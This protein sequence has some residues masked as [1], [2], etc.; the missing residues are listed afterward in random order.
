MMQAKPEVIEEVRRI[1]LVHATHLSRDPRRVP[2]GS[3]HTVKLFGHLAIHRG[4][5]RATMKG[6]T[7]GAEPEDW[8]MCSAPRPGWPDGDAHDAAAIVG[9]RGT[10]LVRGH[11]LLR[12]PR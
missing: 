7:E 3:A 11:E 8:S 4:Q 6:R 12:T 1:L 2:P 9:G 5:A 10:A